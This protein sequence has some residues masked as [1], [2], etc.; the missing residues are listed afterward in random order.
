METITINP[1]VKKEIETRFGVN[2]LSKLMIATYDGVYN[3]AYQNGFNLN[4]G[5][6]IA[7]ESLVELSKTLKS[8]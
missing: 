8:I 7:M 4:Q 3:M 6:K 1:T 5:H 2:S